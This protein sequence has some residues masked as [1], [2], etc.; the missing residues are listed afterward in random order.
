MKPNRLVALLLGTV[1]GGGAGLACA[2]TITLTPS[3]TG[4]NPILR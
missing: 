4:V 3:L 1:H 2:Q